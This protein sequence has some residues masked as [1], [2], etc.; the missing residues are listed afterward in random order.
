LWTKTL[1]NIIIKKIDDSTIC[2]DTPAA[3]F[4]Q[5]F[6]S[7][8][9]NTSVHPIAEMSDLLRSCIIFNQGG[10]YIDSD[11][12]FLKRF[13]DD[14]RNFI[15]E[16][17]GQIMCSV[18]DLNPGDFNLKTI[19]GNLESGYESG[20]WGSLGPLAFQKVYQQNMTGVKFIPE[21]VFYPIGWGEILDLLAEENRSN[22]AFERINQH[23]DTIAIHIYRAMFAFYSRNEY[24]ARSA[25]G[26]LM[27]ENCFPV[28]AAKIEGHF[29]YHNFIG[30]NNG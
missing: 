10:T 17:Q 14:Y 25:L 16:E 3:E 21:H 18:F 23:N 4:Y 9:F 15:P 7:K 29:K 5:V 13:P 22:V 24:S 8:H 6:L 26:I 2:K 19:L 27:R 28:Y 12:I 30:Q 20:K 1:K 11:I